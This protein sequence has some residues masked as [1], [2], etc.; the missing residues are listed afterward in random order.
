VRHR[1]FLQT[2]EVGQR[3]RQD[4]EENRGAEVQDRSEIAQNSTDSDAELEN[5]RMFSIQYKQFSINVQDIFYAA[6]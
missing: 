5:C 3:R 4:C 1:I 6:H 2:K